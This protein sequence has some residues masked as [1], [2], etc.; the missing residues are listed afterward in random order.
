MVCVDFCSARKI[1]MDIIISYISL[2]LFKLQTRVFCNARLQITR[3]RDRPRSIVVR[4]AAGL[5]AHFAGKSEK[6][7]VNL[8]RKFPPRITSSPINSSGVAQLIC[9]E[10]RM[11]P[12]KRAD[13]INE[14]GAGE[15]GK[16]PPTPSR[17]LKGNQS[18]GSSGGGRRKLWLYEKRVGSATTGRSRARRSYIVNN[19]R[20]GMR[21]RDESIREENCNHFFNG[22]GKYFR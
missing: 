1:Q 22:L 7:A 17:L 10:L 18:G 8:R 6:D 15:G 9:F 21:A 11:P 13:K 19:V 3:R 20:G 16:P 14:T 5:N 4:R 2:S 12:V